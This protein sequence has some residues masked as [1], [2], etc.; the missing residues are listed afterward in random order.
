MIVAIKRQFDAI[1]MYG[2]WVDL[3]WPV[4]W[5]GVAA[6]AWSA[7][8]GAIASYSVGMFVWNVVFALQQLKVRAL[9][10]ENE[11]LRRLNQPTNVYNITTGNPLDTSEAVR[12]AARLQHMEF[13]HDRRR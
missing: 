1:K 6:W 5:I 4:G 7:S 8:Q 13:R 3:V 9:T 11:R 2:S 12:Q 10:D